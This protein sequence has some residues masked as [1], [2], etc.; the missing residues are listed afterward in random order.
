VNPAHPTASRAKRA[1]LAILAA[2]FLFAGAA[3]FVKGLGGAVPILQVM[4]FRNLFALPILLPMLRGAGG[5]AALRTSHAAGHAWRTF[6]GL[7]GMATAY[8]GYATMPLAAVTA[9]GFAMPL[10]LTLLAVPL[11]GE[12]VGWRRG[13]A[14]LTGFAGV[15]V[16][17]RP[18]ADGGV[19]LVP[20]L[21]V[22]LG[23]LSWALAMISIRRLGE[24]GEAGVSIVLWFAL[25]SSLVSG[26]ASLPGWIWPEPWQWALL[27][28]TGAVSAVAQVLM[29]EAYRSG[30]PTL[31][32]PFEYSGIVWTTLLGALVW[33]EAP[34]LWD[35][36]GILILVASGLYIWHREMQLGLKR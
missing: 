30:E 6:F 8:Y 35:G 36:A 17:M 13:S 28:G 32:A 25:G 4:L 15:L 18:W 24:A 9:L 20:S 7:I 11:L 22:L 16:M 12:K 21:I 10:F 14:V 19:L 34:D 26:V 2:A 3:A 1:I 5:F 33:A 23:A 31:V 27:I 29:T